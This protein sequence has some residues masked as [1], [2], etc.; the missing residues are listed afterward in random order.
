MIEDFLFK[1]LGLPGCP[2]VVEIEEAGSK[3]VFFL[4]NENMCFFCVFEW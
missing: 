1:Y 3:I 2:E 4:E